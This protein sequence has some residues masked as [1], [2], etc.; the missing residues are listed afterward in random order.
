MTIEEKVMN[1]CKEG[2]ENVE[3]WE[4]MSVSSIQEDGT[5][6]MRVASASLLVRLFVSGDI[7]GEHDAVAAA[8]LLVGLRVGGD[9]RSGGLGDGGER[10]GSE[11]SRDDGQW[12]WTST[13]FDCSALASEGL[14][15]MQLLTYN[16]HFGTT[17]VISRHVESSQLLR[18]E[19]LIPFVFWW[20]KAPIARSGGVYTVIK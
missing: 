10:D 1:Q 5:I 16:S 18:R 2:D 19:C 6:A 7:L 14:S 17:G 3:G 8:A 13:L 20:L 9:I 12:A 11:G 15:F 4:G